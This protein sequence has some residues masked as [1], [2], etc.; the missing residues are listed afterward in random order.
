MLSVLSKIRQVPPKRTLITTIRLEQERNLNSV[1]KMINMHKRIVIQ[2]QHQALTKLNIIIMSL[3]N[4]DN[5]QILV[6]HQAKSN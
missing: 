5:A 1:T 3:H 2:W 4:P 6:G